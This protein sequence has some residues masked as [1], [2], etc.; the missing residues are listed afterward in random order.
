MISHVKY[1]KGMQICMQM[2]CQTILGLYV[3]NVNELSLWYFFFSFFY[4]FFFFFLETNELTESTIIV[5]TFV[6]E[7]NVL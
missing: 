2:P 7:S 4:F 6:S 5:H 1:P 3:L